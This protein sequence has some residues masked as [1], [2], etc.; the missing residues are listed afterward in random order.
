M[1]TP[2]DIEAAGAS[3]A[4]PHRAHN[5]DSFAVLSELGLFM[6]ADGVGG[7]ASGEVASRMAIDTVRAFFEQDDREAI[8]PLGVDPSFT[9]DEAL[10][11][12]SLWRAN[13]RILDAGQREAATRGMAATFAGVRVCGTGF[14]A[15]HVGDSRVYR[16]RDQHLD[17]LTEDHTLRGEYDQR[18]RQPDAPPLRLDGINLD[19][20][21]RALGL[22][23]TVDVDTRVESAAPGDIVLVCSDGLTGPVSEEELTAI[24][25]DA[26]NL[27]TTAQRLIERAHT[28]GGRDDVTCV[29]V[30]WRTPAQPRP[31]APTRRH[32]AFTLPSL[33]P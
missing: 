21:T 1:I 28:R 6:V 11:T 25:V 27:D 13:R 32:D 30:R 5:E 17:R 4:G 22:E 14:C 2:R 16:L 33:T 26:G 3:R 8:W 10:L 15:V 19:L 7:A 9:R 29:L 20:L 24:L 23:P 18:M 12:Q 31:T